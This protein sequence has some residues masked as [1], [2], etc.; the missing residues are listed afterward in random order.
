MVSWGQKLSGLSNAREPRAKQVT[1]EGIRKSFRGVSLSHCFNIPF[2]KNLFI[3]AFLAK[4]LIV[5]D[6]ILFGIKV[7]YNFMFLPTPLVGIV[8]HVFDLFDVIGY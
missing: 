1:Y 4:S 6:K 3:K 2:F 5:S 8:I 7:F